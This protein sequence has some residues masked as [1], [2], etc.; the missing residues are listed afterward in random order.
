MDKEESADLERW[1]GL[2][3]NKL[4]YIEL[5]TLNALTERRENRN[6]TVKKVKEM[7]IFLL[8]DENQEKL[9]CFNYL[10]MPWQD[11]VTSAPHVPAQQRRE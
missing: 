2:T 7:A 6:K 8:S 11:T 9:F 10:E 5:K 1:G 4:G 3:M